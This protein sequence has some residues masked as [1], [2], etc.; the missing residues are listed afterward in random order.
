ME[1][2]AGGDGADAPASASATSM[3]SERMDQ[4]WAWSDFVQR[5]RKI[6]CWRSDG[7]G[8]VIARLDLGW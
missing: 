3:G 6:M 2:T 1:E 8:W 4:R 7:G 5:Q